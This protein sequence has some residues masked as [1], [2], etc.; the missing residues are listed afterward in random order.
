MQIDDAS[1][2]FG[3]SLTFKV[4][5][6]VS[7]IVKGF[8]FWPNESLLLQRKKPGLKKDDGR[9]YFRSKSHAGKGQKGKKTFFDADRRRM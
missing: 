3:F 4:R 9:G 5:I 8:T 2:F 7:D 6:E 1:G